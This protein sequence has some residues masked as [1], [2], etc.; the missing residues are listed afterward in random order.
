[1]FSGWFCKFCFYNFTS[2]EHPFFG[3]SFRQQHQIT[4]PAV[5]EGSVWLLLTKN[6]LFLQLLA[7]DA[8]SVWTVPA[9]LAE[10]ISPKDLGGGQMIVILWVVSRR[11]SATFRFIQNSYLNHRATQNVVSFLSFLPGRIFA[12]HESQND[13]HL[14]SS[15]RS[16]A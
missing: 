1:M 9:A 4:P 13:A 11:N 8:V 3:A 2:H 12:T 10:S 14:A 16:G 7:G 5:A 6:P 15:L